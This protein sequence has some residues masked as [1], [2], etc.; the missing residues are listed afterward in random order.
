MDDPQEEDCE[1]AMFEHFAD[2]YNAF[3]NGR[4]DYTEE[5]NALQQVPTL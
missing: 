1:R 5:L 2:C 3:Q 4:D